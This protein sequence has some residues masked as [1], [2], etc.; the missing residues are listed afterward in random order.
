MRVR[1]PER[2]RRS[3]PSLPSSKALLHGHC[4][5]KAMFGTSGTHRLLDRVEGLQWREVDSGCCGMAGS[6]GF[7][8]YDLSMKIGEQRLLPAV[9]DAMADDPATTVIASG[10]SCRHQ[11]ADGAGVEALHLVEVLRADAKTSSA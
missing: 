9:R 5:Q 10:F 7:E 4:H 2:L 8:H 6:F 11:L 1:L 3:K